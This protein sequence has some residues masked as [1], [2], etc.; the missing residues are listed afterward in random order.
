MNFKVRSKA[1]IRQHAGQSPCRNKTDAA[2]LL[3]REYAQLGHTMMMKRMQRSASATAIM[4]SL[5][6]Q[7]QPYFVSKMNFGRVL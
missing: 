5:R 1:K 3:C 2:E 7:V 4:V 6:N